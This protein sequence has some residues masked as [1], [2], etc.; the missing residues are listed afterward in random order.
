MTIF[1]IVLSCIVLGYLFGSIP[2]SVIIGKV[3]F[4]K[5]VRDYGSKNA[6]GTNAGRVFGKKVGLIVIFLDILKTIIPIYAAYCV[7][8][9]TSLNQYSMQELG[10]I[11]TAFSCLIGHCFPIFA[12]FKGGKAVSSFAAICIATNWLIT[13]VGLFVFLLILKLKK[14]VSLSSI[15]TSIFLTLFSLLDIYVFNGLGMWLFPSSIYYFVLL[16]CSTILLII[17]HHANIS[18]LVHHEERKITWMK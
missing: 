16:L 12:Q 15:L 1:L 5:D 2:S 11:I 8:A 18:R 4:H 9:Y 3:F 6:G 10:Y 13:L 14:Y 17:R 7:L